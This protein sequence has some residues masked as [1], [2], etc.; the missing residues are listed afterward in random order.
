MT[1]DKSN[2]CS[3]NKG[4]TIYESS[5]GEALICSDSEEEAIKLKEDKRKFKF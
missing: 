1:Q 3:I 5:H 2:M 4:F